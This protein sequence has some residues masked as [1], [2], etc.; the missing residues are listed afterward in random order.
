MNNSSYDD[1]ENIVQFLQQNYPIA[2]PP[3]CNLEQRLM[4]SVA[5]QPQQKSKHSSSLIWT[6]PSAIAT[7]VLFTS[8][9]LGLKTPQVAIKTEELENFILNSW[10]GTI[11]RDSHTIS[12]GLETY[13][14]LP[15]TSESQ[16]SLSLSAH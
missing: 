9:T 7:G 13:W 1:H 14:L 15:T 8:V 11:A 5:R 4:E 12:D 6:I 3:S 2:P 10:N 16:A